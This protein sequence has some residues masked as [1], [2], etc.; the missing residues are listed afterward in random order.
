MKK[1]LFWCGI[2]LVGLVGCIQEDDTPILSE[3]AASHEA[4]VL[5]DGWEFWADISN[6]GLSNALQTGQW[7]V[8]GTPIATGLAWE[9]QYPEYD[10]IGWYRILLPEVP[11]EKAF[12]FIADVDDTA[13]VWLDGVLIGELTQEA[14]LYVQ[15]LPVESLSDRW[16]VIRVEDLGGFGG[17]KS[18]IRLGKSAISAVD[19]AH[20]GLYLSSY[21][22]DVFLPEW[23]RGGAMAWAMTGGLGRDDETLVSRHGAIAPYAEAPT[24][25]AWLMNNRSGQIYSGNV[26]NVRFSLIQNIPV[27]QWEWEAEGVQVRSVA[28][29]DSES[30][31]VRWRLWVDNTNSTDNW[32]LLVVV[33]HLG[34]NRQVRAIDHLSLKNPRRMWVN[35]HPFLVSAQVPE[36]VGAGWWDSIVESYR[37]GHHWAEQVADCELLGNKL[38]GRAGGVMLFS[39]PF[40]KEHVLD[41]GMIASPNGQFPSMDVD[42]GVRLESAVRSLVSAT[43]KAI[44]HLPDSA[45][46][47]AMTASLGYLLLADDSDGP[48]PGALAHDAVWTRDSAYIGLALLK[49]GH[50][51]IVKRYVERLFM[52]QEKNGRVPPIQGDKIPWKNE[53]WDAQGQ[54]IFLAMQYYTFTGDK[55]FLSEIY[56][57]IRLAVSFIQDLRK[58]TEDLE[59]ERFKGI[60]PMSLSAEDLGDGEQHYYWDNYWTIVGLRQ[61]SSSARILGF[62]SDANQWGEEADRLLSDVYRSITLVMG[63][64]KIEDVPYLPASVETIDNSGMARGSVPL[65]YPYEIE[66]TDSQWVQRAFDFY[67]ERW[68]EPSQGGY[69]HREGQFWPY[70]GIELAH[71]YQRLGRGDI[72]HQILGWTIAHQTLPGTYAWAEQVSPQTLGFT[73]GD[74]PHAWMGAS[75]YNLIRNLVVMELDKQLILF[76]GA[77]L[78]WFENSRKLGVEHV[79]T[80]Y[81]PLTMG[82]ESSLTIDNGRWIGTL[83]L[84]LEGATPTEGF[85]WRLPQDP[86]KIEFDGGAVELEN[87]VLSWTADVKQI[88]LTFK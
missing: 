25:E 27:P 87:G 6:T 2:L 85:V 1:L 29:Y 16:L 82:I 13:Q 35:G 19:E 62:E 74:M 37:N 75:L 78:W 69:V 12:L 77:P 71:V 32:S 70:G 60:L 58:S 33:R 59:D 49:A 57:N 39:L 28:F 38:N 67:H 47:E 15:E 52:G 36:K 72:L 22:D 48:H 68:I 53:E 17:I 7:A 88:T 10:G 30:D 40:Q 9:T 73:G 26:Q 3:C 63:V 83:T 14:N 46:S 4:I 80:Y 23:T 56:P 20:Y 18:S 42:A 66:Q 64:E 34:V 84:S 41:F 76:E 55:A 50:P 44:F 8:T 79:P 51:E 54:A 86:S 81:G 24:I 45:L 61:A 31:G 11:W 43:E 5:A 21:L 65:L